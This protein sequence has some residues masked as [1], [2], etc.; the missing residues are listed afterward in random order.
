MSD[1]EGEA[2]PEVNDSQRDEQARQ[3][4]AA[5]AI[6]RGAEDTS[7]TRAPDDLRVGHT[8]IVPARRGG[9]WRRNWDPAS[10]EAVS[11]LGD[12]AQWQ[13]RRRAVI[14]WDPAAIED[15]S[16]DAPPIISDAEALRERID[17]DGD[18]ALSEIF[19]PWCEQMLARVLPGWAHRSLEI[20]RDPR[21]RQPFVASER[22]WFAAAARKPQRGK[23]KHGAPL[24][25]VLPA[26]AWTEGG[27]SF[28]GARPVLLAEHLE[29]VGAVAA[30]LARHVGVAV[31]LAG[32]V[33]LAGRLHDLGKADSRFQLLL[34]G[35]DAVAM[36]GSEFA[37][38]VA[39]GQGEPC[40]AAPCAASLP[41]SRGDAA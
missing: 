14:R 7:V 18:A 10:Q 3:P 40:A 31:S 35:G 41:L 25:G 23:D 29:G 22:G 33:A 1:V 38:Q 30:E 9:L 28:N 27:G 32:D 8:L 20:L 6:W 37:R 26:E 2:P 4:I 39:A 34:H 21:Q 19:E 17:D 11:D 13:H 36:A 16:N 15:W 24:I 5:V 12:E